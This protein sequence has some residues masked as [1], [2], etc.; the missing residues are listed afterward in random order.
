MDL[1]IKIKLSFII[2]RKS[3]MFNDFATAI[4]FFLLAIKS[5]FEKNQ[6]YVVNQLERYFKKKNYYLFNIDEEIQ[7]YK[8]VN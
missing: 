1:L 5:G 6:L 4:L 8:M 3:F 7:Y 2:I